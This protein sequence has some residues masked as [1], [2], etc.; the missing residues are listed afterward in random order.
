[1]T[2]TSITI[3]PHFT[4]R[5]REVI[6]FHSKIRYEHEVTEGYPQKLLQQKS[7]GRHIYIQKCLKTS[8]VFIM[9][10]KSTGFC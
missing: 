2:V 10:E 5:P 9:Y 1:M 8:K 7:K 3:I 4:L 6:M